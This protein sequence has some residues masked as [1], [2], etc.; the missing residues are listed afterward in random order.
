M[1]KFYV[2]NICYL[3]YD[4]NK[5]VHYHNDRDH[6]KVE[7]GNPPKLFKQVFGQEVQ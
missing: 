3:N 6:Q 5:D 4:H 7:V 2:K 1:F